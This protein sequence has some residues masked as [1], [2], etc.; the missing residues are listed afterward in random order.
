MSI[1][2][3]AIHD[4]DPASV[5]DLVMAH[6]RS[7]RGFVAA[8]G[9]RVDVVD[10]LSQEVFV[11]AL[12]RLDQLQDLEV[13]PRFLKGIARNVVHEYHRR[14][15]HRCADYL[16]MAEELCAA[17]DPE[18]VDRDLITKLRACLQLLPPRA[19]RM[20]DLRYGDDASAET[21]G[22]ELGLKDATVRVALL[23]AREALVS[24]MGQRSVGT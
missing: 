15:R 3:A 17:E 22:R 19:R 5:S 11:R 20:I 10:D 23:R 12:R 1:T 13:F 14:E 24:C 8:L 9:V 18:P 6:Q 21:I 2:L 4:G 16:A 7:L